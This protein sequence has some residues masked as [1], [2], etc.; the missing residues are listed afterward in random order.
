MHR[1]CTVATAAVA[2]VVRFES[3]IS[4]LSLQISSHSKEKRKE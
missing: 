1:H 3:K 2:Q 4:F